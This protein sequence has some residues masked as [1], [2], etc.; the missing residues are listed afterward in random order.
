MRYHPPAARRSGALILTL[1][2]ALTLALTLA[3]CAPS[4]VVQ[5]TPPHPTPTT[6]IPTTPPKVAP[7]IP[8]IH[9]ISLGSYKANW[10]LAGAAGL[11]LQP[12]VPPPSGPVKS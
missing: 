8:P 10:V 9:T 5:P 4:A 12:P 3:A 6:P 11:V 1:P 7:T 2:L